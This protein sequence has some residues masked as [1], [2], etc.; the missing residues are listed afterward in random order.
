M[1][2]SLPSAIAATLIFLV[3]YALI[4]T[5]RMH[6][7]LVA[8][9][10]A[11]LVLSLRLVKQNVALGGGLHGVD[12][13][14]IFLLLAMMIIVAV[15]RRTGL[16]Q[17]LAIKAAK[18][19]RGQPARVLVLLAAVTAGLSALLDNVTTV[20]FMVP[21]ALLIADGLG[22]NPLPLL[23]TQIL[24]SNIGGTATLIGDPP[25]IMI[26]G[27]ARL[28]FVDFLVDLLPIAVIV[29]AACI[30]LVLWMFRRDLVPPPDAQARA[31]G[32]DESRAITDRGLCYRCLAVLALTFLGF[33]AHGKLHLQPATIALAG[34][35]LLLLS[36]NTEI[37]EV[38]EEIEWS[39]L[40]F[41]VGLFVM[42]AALV[43]TGVVGWVA[44]GLTLRAEHSPTGA[45]IGL[46]W[47]SALASGIVDNI[48]FVAAA[49]PML[50]ELAAGFAN[51]PVPALTAA[52]LHTPTMMGYWWALAL[53]A[54]LGGNATLIGASA[55]V[56]VVG[57]AERSGTPIAF[58]QYLRYGIPVTFLSI[59]LSMFYIWLRYL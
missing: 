36:T 28:G 22:M 3:A 30:P 35:V 11:A 27:A 59:L 57:I 33:F 46:L 40:L 56:V 50:R 49:N 4:A 19:A 5:E 7:T 1:I 44:R 48:P 55:N 26:A 25:N 58:K 39:T 14:V 16:F 17:W 8:L 37:S 6:R 52:H 18:L 51:I 2:H 10:G 29:F 42:V 47:A 38:L 9:A 53:G 32:F 13:N 12:W 54:C 15:T 41:F 43:E 23:V 21:I 31:A 24:A 20:L 45:G 34:A